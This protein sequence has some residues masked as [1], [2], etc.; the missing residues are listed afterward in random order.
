VIFL[1]SIPSAIYSIGYLKHEYSPRKIFLAWVLLA[2]FVGSMVLVV[3]VSNAFAFLVAWEM[4]SLISYFFVVFDSE[5]DRSVQAGTI[6]F[7]MTHI[8]TAFLIAG[9]MIIYKYAHSFDLNAMKEACLLI[10]AGVK[11]T[12]FVFFLLAF[13][14][15]AGIVPLHIW[16]PYAHPQ[17]P[18]HISSI[19][20]GVMIKMAVYGLLRFVIGV[21]GVSALWWGI[22][23][24]ILAIISWLAGILYALMEHDLK[25]LLAYSSVENMGI[26]WLGVGLA[27]VAANLQ[28]SSLAVFA[29]LAGLYHLLN[30]AVFKGLLFL[31]AGS[32]YKATGTRDIEKLG[33]LIKLMP[34]TAL[35]FLIGALAISAIPPLNGFVSEW[36]MLQALLKGVQQASGEM[37]LFFGLGAAG[38]ILTSGL[39]AACFVKAFGITF[40]ARPRTAHAEKAKEVNIFM[41]SGM[42]LLAMFAVT[43]GLFAL[44]IIAV[45][46]TI[47]AST[48]NQSL[49][50][51]SITILALNTPLLLVII[52]VS[53]VLAYA[54]YR[55]LGTSK[56]VAYKTWDCGYYQLAAR[57]E[58]TAT[59]F[60]KPFRMA[61]SFFLRPY[62]K[63]Q[64]VK[65]SPYHVSSFSYETR[66]TM[67][68]REFI[69]KPLLGSVYG[70]AK[71]LR[72]IQPGSIHL[73]LG[74][75][76]ATA[77]LLLVFRGVF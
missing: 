70:L 45:L 25:R 27:M 66:N 4:M 35:L 32:V 58:Y 67:V 10:P 52:C 24:I 18:S 38:L 17:A 15:K 28:L 23:I 9:I 72:R 34:V 76:F 30:H 61:F 39:A 53:G 37:K 69:Y 42:G 41:L 16:L 56:A 54:V 71:Y 60:S 49:Y 13:G 1:V 26:I 68:F 44:P 64:K 22:T 47:A 14:T 55:Y 48:L 7:V 21:L 20:S 19:M 2:G 31:G 74:Y 5:K 77:F 65:V 40:L 73:Y 8:G 33:G 62:H 46:T 29:L 6:Y 43:C 36:L 50:L 51:A 75:I 11:N 59:A 12:I 63:T 57:N 3:T